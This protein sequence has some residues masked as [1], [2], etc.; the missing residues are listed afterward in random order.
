MDR[1][2]NIVLLSGG[3]DS[4]VVVAHMIDK[5]LQFEA[6]FLD[7]QEPFTREE[8]HH[9][10]YIVGY[11][12]LTAHDIKLLQLE[13]YKAREGFSPEAAPD[14]R[15]IPLRYYSML[16]MVVNRF[17]CKSLRIYMGTCA[18]DSAAPDSNIAAIESI[19]Q[20]I[21]RSMFWVDF[22]IV[23]PLRFKTKEQVVQMATDLNV[24][25]HLTY[26]CVKGGKTECGQCFSCKS[27]LEA[28][29]KE[30]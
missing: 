29:C 30:T 25:L 26:S 13:D 10:N 8:R 24:P 27:K 20:A 2:R 22:G 1:T 23:L 18:S 12:N 17:Y 15:F 16:G 7:M 14:L 28:I 4:T 11:Y 19:E 9:M 3:L 6:V 5:G 21:K